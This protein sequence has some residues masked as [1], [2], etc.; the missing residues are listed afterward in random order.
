[1]KLLLSNDD[2]VHSPGLSILA[3]ALEPQCDRIAV[4]AP[5]RN[6]SGASSALTLTRPLYTQEQSNG[7]YSVDGTP[8]DCIHLAVT[9]MLDFVPDRVISGINIGANLGDD[10]WYSGTVA[11][12]VEGRYLGFAAIA[13]SLVGSTHFATAGKVVAEL[14]KADCTMPHPANTILNVNV[15]DLPYSQIRGYTITRFGMRHAAL[16]CIQTTTPRGTPCYWIAEAGAPQDNAPDTDFAAV[17]AGYVSI[18]PMRIDLTNHQYLPAMQRWI[19]SSHLA[20]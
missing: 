19:K 1:M 6:L 12:A 10:V 7:F 2:G 18:T 14:I 11:A 5:D 20:Q 16:P 3:Q 15:P 8:A 13:V 9:G 17:E 4:V